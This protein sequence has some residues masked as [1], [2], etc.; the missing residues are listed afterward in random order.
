ML[1]GIY[2]VYDV[3]ARAYLPPF[4][5]PEDGMARRTFGDCCNDKNHQFG[6]HPEDYTLFKLGE[7][8]SVNAKYVLKEAPESLGVGIEYLV[9]KE[10]EKQLNLIEE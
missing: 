8:D 7:W 3:K 5:L 10:D 4:N 6:A 1:F 2:T 9:P